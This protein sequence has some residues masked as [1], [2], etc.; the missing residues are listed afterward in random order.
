MCGE[1]EVWDREGHS[2]GV[3]TA[4]RNREPG[5]LLLVETTSQA[6]CREQAMHHLITYAIA[7]H[8]LLS[9]C[10]KYNKASG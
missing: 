1:K 8:L 9:L 6:D 7:F 10:T 3:V 2:V 4:R 5:E